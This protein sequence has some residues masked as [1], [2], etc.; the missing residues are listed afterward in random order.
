MIQIASFKGKNR[1]PLANE[2]LK[3]K[4]DED[5]IQI[6]FDHHKIDIVHSIPDNGHTQTCFQ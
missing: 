5:V 3:N 1:L 6:V 4:N 2:F